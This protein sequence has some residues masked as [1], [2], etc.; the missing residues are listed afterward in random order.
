MSDE[1]KDNLGAAEQRQT[2]TQRTFDSFAEELLLQG[3]ISDNDLI[4]YAPDY[5]AGLP[6]KTGD[7]P[8]EN[9]GAQDYLVP[10]FGSFLALGLM[11]AGPTVL[12]KILEWY[13]VH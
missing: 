3:L 13:N 11:Q 2:R 5:E 10:L 1:L 9:I 7:R 6:E 4:M 12:A 8:G